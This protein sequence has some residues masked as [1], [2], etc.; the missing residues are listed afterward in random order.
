MVKPA[1]AVALA[2]LF[3]LAVLLLAGCD[4]SP[5]EPTEVPGAP[6]K[7][8]T[9]SQPTAMPTTEVDSTPVP[10]VITL[11]IWTTEA[12]S[13][14]E[15]ITSGE[16]LAAQVLGFQETYPDVRLEFL[17]K[18]PY[19]KGGMLDYLLTTQAAVP[20]LLP[21]LAILD[22]DE[23]GVAVQAGAVQPLDDLLPAELVTDL[24][25]AA[26]E[27]ATVQGR[28]YALQF[29]TDLEHL[30]YNT[31][32]M[33]VP[34][35][36][37]P[38]VLSNPGPYAFPAGGQAGLV[39]DAFLIQYLAVQPA[40][41][42]EAAGGLELDQDQL[43][44]VL[45]YYQDGMSRGVYA[46]DLLEVHT[47]DDTWQDYQGG[48]A[49]LAHVSAHRYLADRGSLQ[50]TA[51][52]FIPAIDGPAEAINQGWGLILVASDPVRQSAVADFM[53][54][55]LAPETNAAW[56]RASGFLPTRQAAL[57]LWDQEDSYVPFAHQQL[58]AA[59]ARPVIANYTKVAA[60][61]QVAVVNVLT[62]VATPEEAAA[63]IIQDSR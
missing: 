15:A 29:L 48:K 61:M 33:T 20:D 11:T 25:P 6:T 5:A 35:R 1:L 43:A 60:A 45:Q 50:G 30:V 38:G 26:R 34:P 13:P 51:P 56:N 9:P 10:T 28:F 27:A 21:D 2:L 47:T 14:T 32:Q 58:L 36:S 23:L 42:G 3:T 57:A 22:M 39:N 59:Q 19:G 62:G 44:A 53:V 12:F 37:W 7:A 49:S 52:A 16:V 46:A 41:S 63:Q 31:G 18:Q 4:L 8:P 40:S 24:Y 54:Y 55:M 17:L